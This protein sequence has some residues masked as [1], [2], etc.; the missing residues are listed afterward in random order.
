MGKNF[1]KKRR[2]SSRSFLFP[3]KK[4]AEVINSNPSMKNS[5]LYHEKNKENIE[6]QDYERYNSE[7]QNK[8]NKQSEI[9][10]LNNDNQE[11][12]KI[13]GIS[14]SCQTDETY[15]NNL[16]NSQNKSKKLILIK[17]QSP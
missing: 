8:Y 1:N 7:E 10:K 9:K 6:N 14:A 3:K 11:Y 4:E 17:N 5:D 15:Y 16:I 2:N 12:F 13:K